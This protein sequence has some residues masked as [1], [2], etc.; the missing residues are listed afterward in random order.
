MA[1]KF[2]IRTGGGGA[3]DVDVDTAAGYEGKVSDVVRRILAEHADDSREEQ[4]LLDGPVVF[5]QLADGVEMP[6]SGHDSWSDVVNKMRESSVYE[7]GLAQRHIGGT[8]Q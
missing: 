1:S 5:D 8:A 3:K 7:I 2:K 4:K 6:L